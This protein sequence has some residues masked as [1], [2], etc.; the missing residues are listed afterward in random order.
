MR[1][2]CLLVFF[3]ACST[4][5]VAQTDSITARIVLIGDA[6]Q[7]TNGHHP[8]V[9]AVKELIPMDTKTTVLYLGDNLYKSG[10]PDE[11]YSYYMAARS[12]LDTQL[13]VADNSPSKIYMIPG[14]HDWE[15]GK[16]NGYETIMREQSYVNQLGKKNVQ[17]LPENGCPGPIEVSISPDIT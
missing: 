16:P 5:A 13:S 3:F 4:I 10:L 14:N 1:I 6:G 2:V 15:N 11:A 17:F 12:V 7:F 8:V 9:D